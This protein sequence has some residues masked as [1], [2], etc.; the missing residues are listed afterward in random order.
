M[1]RFIILIVFGLFAGEIA[2]DFT[3]PKLA[4]G[5]VV[6]AWV[7]LLVIHELGH[8]VAARLLGGHVAGVVIGFGRQRWSGRVGGIEFEWRSIPIEGFTLTRGVEGRFSRALVY[9]AGPVAEI[10]VSGII[11]VVMGFDTVTSPSNSVIV[12]GAQSVC[13]AALVS[14]VV[15]LIPAEVSQGDSEGNQEFV[16]N[17]GLGMIR[18]L[19]GHY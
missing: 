15:N 2:R 19:F 13:I 4:A 9:L 7:P 17:D 3:P 6:I 11:V 10:A 18:S 14:A 1:I 16:A 12:I 8:A 5:F